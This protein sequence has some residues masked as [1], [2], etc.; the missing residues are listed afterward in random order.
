MLAFCGDVGLPPLSALVQLLDLDSDMVVFC[1]G[2]PATDFML[3]VE[4]GVQVGAQQQTA[5]QTRTAINLQ[6]PPL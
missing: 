5:N 2:Q 6:H 1:E 4:G 3:L